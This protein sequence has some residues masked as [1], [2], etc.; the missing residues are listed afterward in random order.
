MIPDVVMRID[1]RQ[2]GFENV[3]AK[4]AEPFRIGQRP[5][6][7]TGFDGGHGGLPEKVGA[8]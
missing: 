4:L 3:L 6:I 5:R 1:D 8:I 2:L 7:G